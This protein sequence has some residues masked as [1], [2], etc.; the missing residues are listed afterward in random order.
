METCFNLGYGGWC[1]ITPPDKINYKYFDAN[2][3]GAT[4]LKT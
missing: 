3:T 1:A 2:V 4:G